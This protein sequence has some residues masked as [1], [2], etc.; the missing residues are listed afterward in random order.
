MRAAAAV[1]WL[2]VRQLLPTPPPAHT[3]AALSCQPRNM[4]GR[5]AEEKSSSSSAPPQQRSQQQ[6]EDDSS[7]A[8]S[9][10]S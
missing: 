5:P 7:S 9:T 1:C 3:A 2:Q 4:K 6:D 10:G 8:R